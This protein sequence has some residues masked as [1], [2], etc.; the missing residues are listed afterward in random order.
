MKTQKE[1]KAEQMKNPDFAK[2][3]HELKPEIQNILLNISAPSIP[4]EMKHEN[5]KCKNP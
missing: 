4:T 2:T 3:Y 5:Q 1:Y